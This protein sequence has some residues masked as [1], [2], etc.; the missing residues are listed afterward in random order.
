MEKGR[1]FFCALGHRPTLLTNPAMASNF[2]SAIQ[3]ILGDL[4][5]DTTPSA[6]LSQSDEEIKLKGGIVNIFMRT[7]LAIAATLCLGLKSLPAQQPAAGAP[8]RRASEGEGGRQFVDT[9]LTCHGN[10]A[11]PNAPEPAALKRMA[12]EHIYRVLTTGVMK[13]IAKDLSDTNKRPIATWV[14]GR[15]IEEGQSGDAKAMPNG[16]S[17]NPPIQSLT[18]VPSW[19]GWG[20]DTSN[21]RFHPRKAAGYRRRRFRD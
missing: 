20:A 12:P 4:E 1:V 10:A 13:D 17:G 16:C 9:C 2:F 18:N 14:G 6:R 8:P 3:F 15:R 21:T 5:A 19:N 7:F 11:M